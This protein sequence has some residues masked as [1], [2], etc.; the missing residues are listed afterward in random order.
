MALLGQKTENQWVGV[1]S[2]IMDQLISAVG[3]KDHAVLIDCRSLET[4]SFPLPKDTVVVIMDTGTRR[5]LVDSAYNERRSQCE[6]AVK[7]FGVRAL[8][9]VS[10]SQLE[11]RAKELSEL[12]YKRAKHVISENERTLEAAEAMKKGDALLLG[13]LMNAS[14]ESL[15][16]DFEVSSD[17]L[18]VIV[19]CALGQ[20]GC[21]GARMTGAGF[22]GCAVA[23]V[24]ADKAEAFVKA[25]SQGYQSKTNKE[26]QIYVCQ[27]VEGASTVS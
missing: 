24:E 16:D 26:P 1:N 17:A 9:D 10:L 15:R 22:G 2:G 6:E 5:G 23:L 8:R 11:A 3:E 4:Q 12:T 14:H 18:N 13:G 7:F 21:Y 25:V 20:D 19:E 27:A